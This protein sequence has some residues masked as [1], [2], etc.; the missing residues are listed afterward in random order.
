LDAIEMI[1]K[2]HFSQSSTSSKV[3]KRL[4]SGANG[5]SITDLDEFALTTI[6]KKKTAET[7]VSKRK[8]T[9]KKTD[10]QKQNVLPDTNIYSANGTNVTSTGTHNVQLPPIAYILPSNTSSMI[11]PSQSNTSSMISPS[12]PNINSYL[13]LQNLPSTSYMQ[14]Q[15][16]FNS[17]KPLET[18]SNCSQCHRILCWECSYK[19]DKNY[20]LCHICRSYY[21]SQQQIYFSQTLYQ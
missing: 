21:T 11:S 14:C 7:K 6:R 5:R 18:T 13:P 17:I 2:K 4:V 20:Q 3:K 16:C 8:Y 9:K 15:L 19:I 12:Q 10:T 1:V